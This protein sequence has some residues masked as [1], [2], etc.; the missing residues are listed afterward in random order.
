VHDAFGREVKVGD[1]VMVPFKVTAVHASPEYCNVNLDTVA[2]MPP[3]TYGN[4][5]V[6]NTKQ[7]LRA[8]PGDDLAFVVLEEDGKRS[9]ARP[10]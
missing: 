5:M 8:N 10:V 2:S 6:A 4:S 7:T 3:Y 1:T 9:L